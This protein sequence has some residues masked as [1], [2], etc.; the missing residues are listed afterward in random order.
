MRHI[1][2]CTQGVCIETILGLNTELMASPPWP[3]SQISNLKSQIS[4]LKSQISNLK[5]QISNLRFEIGKWKSERG[6]TK[7][8][9]RGIRGSPGV[10]V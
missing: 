4:N 5:S 8:I 9:L 7:D 6:A 10:G 3:Q 2:G 1:S